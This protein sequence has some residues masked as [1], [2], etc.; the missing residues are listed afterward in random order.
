MTRLLADFGHDLPTTPA[1]PPTPRSRGCYRRTPRRGP[2]QAGRGWAASPA[3]PVSTWRMTSDQAPVLWPFIATPGLPPT[4]AQMGIDVL[5]G[6]S[7]H[8]DPFGW[9]LR[10]DVPVTNPNVI[11][12]GKP[13]RGKSA[14]T[15]AFILRM[16]DFGYRSLILGDPKDEYE[17]LC[18]F[19]GVEPFRIGPGLPARINPL[20]FGPLGQDWDTLDREA[21]H[22]RSAIVFARWLTLIRGLVGSQRVGAHPVPFGPVEE[23]V[24]KAALRD[25]TGHGSG[26]TTLT[27]TTI[28]QLWHLL[29]TPTT[30]LVAAC[31]YGSTRHF[32]DETRLLRD[33]LGQLVDGALA[34]LFDDHTTI[35]V[36]WAAPIQSLSL[37]RLMP[38]GDEAVG[39]ALTCLSS[40]GRGMRELAARRRPADHRARRGL[41]ADAPG[42]RG[43]EVLRRGPAPVPRRRR[44]PVGQRPQTL[45]PALRRRRRLPGR[46]HRQGPA[47]PD[48]HQ[49]PA[50]PGPRRRRRARDPPR[51]RPDR[52]RRRHRLGHA[53][54][55]PRPVV[56]RRTALQGPDRPAPPRSPAHLHQRRHRRRRLNS[57]GRC[58]SDESKTWW[59]LTLIAAL[60]L[61][62]PFGA[63]LLLAA[64]LTPAVAAQQGPDCGTTPA[65]TG[66]WR[67][68]FAQAYTRTS[69]FGMRF[70]PIYHRWRLHSG[71]DLVSLPEPGPVLAAH[72]G[73]VTA[74]GS[75]GSYGNAVDIDHGAGVLTRYAHLARIDP[76]IAVGAT[77][78][79]GD[80]IG[81]E[82][83]T[84]ASTGNHLHFEIRLNGEPVDPLPF[85]AAHGAPLDGKA[86]PTTAPTHP[87][88][89]AAPAAG[90]GCCH[91]PGNRA[92]TP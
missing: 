66:P 86:G 29:T 14:T 6:G 16:M 32:L 79:A 73:T 7:F 9:V 47:P 64:V 56:R 30:D 54:Q 68:P 83:S 23:H 18:R 75:R 69:P 27:E 4:G 88:P 92:A 49:D 35:D 21:T 77:L 63:A 60:I 37:S 31:R 25:L 19:L 53:R 65:A 61:G 62:A 10:D 8:A 15:K 71:A 52:P 26:A 40:W 74:A 59:A 3:A 11:C 41:E 78:R 80:R 91:Q 12:F 43:R 20:A 34:G 72:D 57:Q 89:T 24:V 90:V 70:H 82:G 45:R 33:A 84:G 2:R 38:L 44:H 42:R 1:P 48:R 51:P 67:P 36:D 5:S 50:R 85:M 87:T 17:P 22:A 58:A 46:H 28:P 55:G 13:G 76:T 81:V 39:I